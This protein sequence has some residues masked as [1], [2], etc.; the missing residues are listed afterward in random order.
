MKARNFFHDSQKQN[1]IRLLQENPGLLG[2]ILADGHL[3]IYQGKTISI[4][5]RLTQMS[6]RQ[7]YLTQIRHEFSIWKKTMIYESP[8]YPQCQLSTN[9][10]KE[11]WMQNSKESIS[12]ACFHA[13]FYQKTTKGKWKKWI[14]RELLSPDAWD[15]KDLVYLYLEDGSHG[16]ASSK[17]II[18]CLDSF[19]KEE[20][21]ILQTVFRQKWNLESYIESSK[22]QAVLFHDVKKEVHRLIFPVSMKQRFWDLVKKDVTPFSCFASKFLVLLDSKE[23]TNSFSKDPHFRPEDG[24]SLKKDE[25]LSEAKDVNS[26]KEDEILSEA[27]DVNSLK[28]E[29]YPTL[30]KEISE[31]CQNIILG[32]ALA[33]TNFQWSYNGSKAMM[34]IRIGKKQ[35]SLYLRK[36]TSWFFQQMASWPGISM[37]RDPNDS[38]QITLPFSTL[39]SNILRLMWI[40]KY[41]QRELQEDWR[42]DWNSEVIAIWYWKKGQNLEQQRGGYLLGCNHLSLKDTEKILE[43][44]NDQY[45][46]NARLWFRKTHFLSRHSSSNREFSSS[47]GE[48]CREIDS[49]PPEKLKANIYIPVAKRKDFE[50]K[51]LEF[52]FTESE[53]MED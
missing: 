5:F 45:Q 7:N 2:H 40:P 44:L 1:V 24:N 43:T 47:D 16:W 18:L 38:W 49:H 46:W 17:G 32:L 35:K 11:F 20:L 37:K 31:H 23:S 52:C 26:L 6:A 33:G 25:I 12:S 48:S 9:W 15:I 39:L 22:V 13:F 19:S 36:L 50:K 8:T 29:V 4:R 41:G 42:H 3:E 51:I 30:K 53:K 28:E 34:K 27:K 21:Q 10:Q 14:S